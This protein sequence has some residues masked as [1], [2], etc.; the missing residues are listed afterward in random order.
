MKRGNCGKV[1]K[2]YKETKGRCYFNKVCLYI[3]LSPL[4]SPH[5]RELECFF[6]PGIERAVFTTEL[7][8]LLS[9]KKGMPECPSCPWC[10]TACS[11]K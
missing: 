11:A 4:T 9:V 3:I 5:L 7:H 10:S 1:T 2:I 8:L 6:P